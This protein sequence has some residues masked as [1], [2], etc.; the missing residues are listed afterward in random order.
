MDWGNFNHVGGSDEDRTRYLLHAMEALFQVSY[1]PDSD[2]NY[3]KN[4]NYCNYYFYVMRAQKKN[5]RWLVRELFHIVARPRRFERP[6][7][8]LGGRYSIQLSYGRSSS[9][10][11]DVFMFDIRFEEGENVVIDFFSIIFI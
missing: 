5:P 4:Q 3:R 8:F 2:I 11:H 10:L 1:G 6:T 9:L 7:P